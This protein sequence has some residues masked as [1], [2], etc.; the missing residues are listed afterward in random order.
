M[1][2]EKIARCLILQYLTQC[3]ADDTEHR[4]ELE[5][6]IDCLKTIWGIN[7]FSVSIPNVH[8]IVDL[9]P[10][11][12]YDTDRA[13]ELKQEGNTLLREG[14]LDGAIA[15]YNEAI[16]T[17][18][19]QST[20]YCNRAAVYSKKGNHQQAIEDCEKAISL[21]QEYATAYSRLGFAYYQLGNVEKA[22][23]AYKRGLRA[24]PNNENL[25]ENLNSLGPDPSAGSATNNANS[26]QMPGGD[27][28]GS[29]LGNFAQNPAMISQLAEKMNSP[30]VQQLMQDP[31]MSSFMEQIK[32][33]PASLFSMMGDPRMQRLFQAIMGG[34]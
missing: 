24:C 13:M 34:H 28:L 6:S 27:V 9:I 21:D 3:C 16:A 1:D 18:P 30:E 4:D 15:K 29:M 19:N 8:S 31:E 23:E 22:R 17:D 2:K 10:A 33:N 20:F 7:D 12:Q 14:N 32:S 5:V 25:K 26:G 11:P